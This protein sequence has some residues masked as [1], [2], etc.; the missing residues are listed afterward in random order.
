MIIR[1]FL[2]PRRQPGQSHSLPHR[3]E[4]W[5]LGRGRGERSNVRVQD[6]PCERGGWSRRGESLYPLLFQ[7]VP[8]RATD[9]SRALFLLL[10][11]HRETEFAVTTLGQEDSASHRSDGRECGLGYQPPE[12]IP[13]A[14]TSE[15]SFIE[16]KEKRLKW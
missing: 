5:G 16:G 13:E 4:N 6:V 3:W 1:A 15:L 12:I 8:Q 14:G 2:S 10:N 11:F 7:T 9:I